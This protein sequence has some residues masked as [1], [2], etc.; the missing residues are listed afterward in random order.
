MDTD[1]NVPGG[2]KWGH[3]LI[4]LNMYILY[5]NS[6]MTY[7]VREHLFIEGANVVEQ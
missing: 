1:N 3:V 7:H 5:V 2:S 6:G 4:I